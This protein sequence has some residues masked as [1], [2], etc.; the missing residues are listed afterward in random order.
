MP[1]GSPGSTLPPFPPRGTH[2]QG[3]ALGRIEHQ[4]AA[5]DGLAVCGHVEG[6]AVLASQHSL[7][8]LL[9]G[10]GRVKSG[11]VPP[12][13]LPA[14]P[15]PAEPSPGTSLGAG[16]KGF[17]PPPPH[18][19][20]GSTPMQGR[21]WALPSRAVGSP[22]PQLCAQALAIGTQSLLC[23]AGDKALQKTQPDLEIAFPLG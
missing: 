18:T 11:R 16:P 7:P 9:G 13:S 5:Q 23:D 20:R 14:C 4:E 3:A 2:L 8:Q 10:R 22:G 19:K 15:G 1:G 21:D 17:P 12:A 6:D